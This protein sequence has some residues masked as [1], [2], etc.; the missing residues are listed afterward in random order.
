VD[1]PE[2]RNV[3]AE[4]SDDLFFFT[5]FCYFQLS[6]SLSH[7]TSQPPVP[8]LQ[9][10]EGCAQRWAP[11]GNFS[12]GGPNASPRGGGGAL[13]GNTCIKIFCST[14]PGGPIASPYGLGGGQ[15]PPGRMPE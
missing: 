8:A 15:S 12:P 11:P 3:A 14:F 10:G 6:F 1:S 7:L 2:G 4:F 9:K 5:H 13:S